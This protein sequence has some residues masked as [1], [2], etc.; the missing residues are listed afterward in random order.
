MVMAEQMCIR[1]NPHRLRIPLETNEVLSPLSIFASKRWEDLLLGRPLPAC[2][3][4]KP[5]C[6]S[7]FASVAKRRISDVMEESAG[8][9]DFG[10]CSLLRFRNSVS[11]TDDIPNDLGGQTRCNR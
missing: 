2:K 8:F 7:E 5:T 6:N 9:G 1:Y 10:N 4:F 11:F 3:G